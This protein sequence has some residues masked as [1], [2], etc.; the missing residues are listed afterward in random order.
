MVKLETVKSVLDEINHYDIPYDI[1][2]FKIDDLK[3]QKLGPVTEKWPIIFLTNQG[4]K[5][6][7]STSDFLKMKKYFK[8]VVVVAMYSGVSADYVLKEEYWHILL[9]KLKYDHNLHFYYDD[10]VIW[11]KTAA[12]LAGLGKIG[13]NRLFWSRKFGFMCKVELMLIDDDIDDTFIQSPRFDHRLALCMKCEEKHCMNAPKGCPVLKEKETYKFFTKCQEES[14]RWVAEN[15]K[16]GYWE[17]DAGSAPWAPPRGDIY[18]CC[19]FC[20]TGCPYSERLVEQNVPEEKRN[21]RY[22]H[23]MYEW[24]FVTP[25]LVPF[26]FRV[27]FHEKKEEL[28][29]YA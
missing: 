11:R 24:P 29:R 8:S 17:K 20:Q 22:F 16:I 18:G 10:Y 2:A 3:Q 19:T 21:R 25:N 28:K 27:K 5:L 12:V 23:Y 1:G 6:A 26:S 7:V 15:K 4:Q 13:E 14:T 9:T